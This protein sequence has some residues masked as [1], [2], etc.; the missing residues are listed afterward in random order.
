[1]KYMPVPPTKTGTRPIACAWASARAASSRQR[2]NRIDLARADMAVEQMRHARLVGIAGLRRQDRR[3]AIDLHGIG[4]DHHAADLLGQRQRFAADLPLA[5]GPAI[6]TASNFMRP[7]C[8][9]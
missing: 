5:V 6:R 7:Q 1:M 8:L 4:I 2:A 9:F 3:F